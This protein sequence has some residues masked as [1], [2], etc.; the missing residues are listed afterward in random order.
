MER[1]R[2][3]DTYKVTEVG[4][5][6]GV[7][8]FSGTDRQDAEEIL[9][10]QRELFPQWRIRYR[11]AYTSDSGD[12]AGWCVDRCGG[13]HRYALWWLIRQ[14]CLRGWEPFAVAHDPSREAYTSPS[15]VFRKRIQG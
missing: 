3:L 10:E 7:V 5:R 15:Y 6:Q 9:A 8:W 14:M 2:T 13:R 12:E 1:R 4:E 11:S